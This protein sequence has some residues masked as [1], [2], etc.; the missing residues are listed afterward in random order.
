VQ[1]QT[2]ESARDMLHLIQGTAASSPV[3]YY[4]AQG[5]Q[6]ACNHPYGSTVLMLSGCAFAPNALDA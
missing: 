2:P 5:R 6:L 4:C 1:R 3:S